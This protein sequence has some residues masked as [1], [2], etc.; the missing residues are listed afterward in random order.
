MVLEAAAQIIM[1]SSRYSVAKEAK[2][3]HVAS[4]KRWSHSSR[5]GICKNRLKLGLPML[6]GRRPILAISE[7][8]MPGHAVQAAGY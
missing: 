5:M 2:S 7:A 8:F 3:S 6:P 4:A 1:F